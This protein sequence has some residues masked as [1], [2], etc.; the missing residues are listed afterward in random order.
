[1]RRLGQDKISVTALSSEDDFENE[2]VLNNFGNTSTCFLN[3]AGK[4]MYNN[5]CTVRK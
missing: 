4:Y 5:I 1:M 2:V 3:G